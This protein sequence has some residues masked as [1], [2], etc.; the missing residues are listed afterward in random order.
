MNRL[1]R[2]RF[3]QYKNRRAAKRRKRITGKHGSF[4]IPTV[5]ERACKYAHQHIRRIGT[6]RKKRGLQRRTRLLIEP[7]RQRKVRHRASELGQRLGTPEY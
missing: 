4:F 3:Q 2:P 5:A 7:Q 6:H 1:Q